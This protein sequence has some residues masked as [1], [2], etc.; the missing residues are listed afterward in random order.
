MNIKNIQPARP[1]SSTS[2]HPLK[3]RNGITRYYLAHEKPPAFPIMPMPIRHSR[4][5]FS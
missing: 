2:G 4:R 3:D 5:S 1:P